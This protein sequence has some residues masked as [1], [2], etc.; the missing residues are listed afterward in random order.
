M[1]LADAAWQA[2]DSTTIQNCW[3]KSG[4]LPATSDSSS[5]Q[6]SPVNHNLH[7]EDPIASAKKSVEATLDDLVLTGALQ[8]IN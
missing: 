7:Q 5:T 4:I 3:Q 2:V 1:R 8:N 6:P